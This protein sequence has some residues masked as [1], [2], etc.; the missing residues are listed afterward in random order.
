MVRT[1]CSAF[2]AVL[3]LSL[4][5]TL[6]A[7][8]EQDR[9]RAV[10]DGPDCGMNAEK[11][12]ERLRVPGLSAA[13]VRN[14][15][16]VCKAVAGMADIEAGRPVTPDTVFVW[17]SVSK[18]VTAVAVMQLVDDGL[19]RLEDDVDDHLPF[20][21]RNPHC[22]DRP[23]TLAQLLSHTSSIR[24]DEDGGVYNGLYV[25]GDS[26]IAL[27]D[28]LE[29]YL[30]PG[31][32][33]Y[34]KKN[35][36]KKCPGKVHDYSNVGAGLL[37]HLVETVSGLPF[38]R[39]TAERLFR[40]LGMDE[41]AWHLAD[42]NLDHVALPY[43]GRP[44]SGFVPVG[45]FGFPTYPDGLLRTSPSQLARFLAMF[46]QF[47]E[48]DGVRV[49]SRNSASAM[50]KRHF[51]K[52]SEDQGLIWQY[53]DIGDQEDLLG[54]SGSD[55]GTSSLMFF[56]PKDGTGVLMVANGRWKWGRAEKVAAKLLEEARNG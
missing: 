47:G 7:C 44:S 56:D 15:R 43:E 29:D 40:P 28:F 54:H 42:L 13:V 26:R 16:V 35:F 24:E 2:A 5:A 27:G 36:K 10:L 48:L 39:F 32:A 38:E 18:T 50:R 1:A 20:S 6:P 19:L 46:I 21:V 17:A 9:E 8:S 14:G 49:L 51:P 55:P 45:H 52:A 37:G 53:E 23:I 11:Q 12:L 3:A 25:K 30:T 33:Y 4:S 31:G 41:T 22:P 34:S